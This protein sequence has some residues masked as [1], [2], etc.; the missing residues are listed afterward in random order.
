MHWAHTSGELFTYAE[1]TRTPT[2]LHAADRC[3]AE[4]LASEIA[5]RY[6]KEHAIPDEPHYPRPTQVAILRDGALAWAVLDHIE[7]NPRCHDQWS[8]VSELSDGR[9][10][11]TVACVAGW[12]VVL[13][14]GTLLPT[15]RVAIGIPDRP[16]LRY[17]PEAVSLDTDEVASVAMTLLGLDSQRALALF[18]E[19]NSVADLRRLVEHYFGPRPTQAA[20][21]TPD[22]AITQLWQ[23]INDPAAKLSILSSLLADLIED[24]QLYTRA[25]NGTEPAEQRRLEIEVEQDLIAARASVDNTAYYI[26]IGDELAVKDRR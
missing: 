14:G 21:Q 8:W 22:E 23:T 6:L 16:L 2:G 13:A 11:G 7:D 15:G 17:E 9:G 3:Q 1:R 10:C 19:Y 18:D 24:E 12:T 26:K 20:P 4:R 5:D 25:S